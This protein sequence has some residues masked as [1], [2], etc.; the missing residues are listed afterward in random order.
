MS[1]NPFNST[2]T[3]PEEVEIAPLMVVD[4]GERVAK[5]MNVSELLKQDYDYQSCTVESQIKNNV[6]LGTITPT[7]QTS[8]KL[9][10]AE[11]FIT[12]AESIKQ[13][14]KSE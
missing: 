5:V 6:Q 11:E 14:T 1:Q 3:N 12:A 2:V 4:Y 10:V 13:E 9:N 8:D 7:Q